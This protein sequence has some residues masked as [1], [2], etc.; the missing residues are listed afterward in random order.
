M[1][2]NN[3]NNEQVNPEL[4]PN[5]NSPKTPQNSTKWQKFKYFMKTKVFT[6]TVGFSVLGVAAVAGVSAALIYKYTKEKFRPVFYNYQS[7]MDDWI[8]NRLGKDFEFK[9][10]GTI[11]EFTKAILTHKTA[12]GIG[13]DAQAAKLIIN[14]YTGTSK[15][16]RFTNKD[17]KN[18][19]GENWDESKSV[20]ANLKNILTDVVFNHLASYDEYFDDIPILDKNGEQ[21]LKADGKPFF[22]KDYATDDPN[23]IHLY[24]YF[25]P[26]FAQDMVIAYNPLKLKKYNDMYKSV[27]MDEPSEPSEDATQE[28]KNQ[29]DKDL[30]AYNLA[31]SKAVEKFFFNVTKDLETKINKDLKTIYDSTKDSQLAQLKNTIPM[32]NALE[33]LR[34]PY[35]KNNDTDAFQYYEYTDAVRDNMI[36]GSSYRWDAT[37]KKHVPQPTGGAIIKETTSVTGKEITTPIYKTL[38][39]QFL[40]LFKDGTGYALNNTAH[41]R[42]SGNGLDLLNTLIDPTKITNVGIIYNGDALDAFYSRDNITNSDVPDGSIRFI[43]P[44][45]NL[46]LVDGLVI[47][48]DTTD[49]VVNTIIESSKDTFLGGLNKPVAQ[50]TEANVSKATFNAA[51]GSKEQQIEAYKAFGSMLNYDYVKYTPAFKLVYDY[52]LNNTFNNP[53]IPSDDPKFTELNDYLKKYVQNLYEIKSSYTIGHRSTDLFKDWSEI[54]YNVNHV[55]ISPVNQKTQTQINT[56]YEQQLKA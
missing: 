2:N 13:N 8:V 20:Q 39:D 14:D 17:F 43:R 12:G 25:I 33:T 11:N 22:N 26:Y 27:N 40:A 5:D 36:Y 46:L 3:L 52:A 41:V 15:L 30:T 45:V 32:I 50:W 49:E 1:D 24:N 4:T 18:I 38:I 55:A 10:F 51:N 29:Y 23:K 47:S 35:G 53:I 6:K 16:R 37:L 21:K 54:T 31:Y 7:Y 56:Y 44:S 19:F 9:Q 28:E 48:E 34:N 42:T